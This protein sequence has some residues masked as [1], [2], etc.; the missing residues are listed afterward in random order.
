MM[1]TGASNPTILSM[2]CGLLVVL[3]ALPGTASGEILLED[4]DTPGDGLIKRDTE[5]GLGWLDLS[6]TGVP[7]GEPGISVDAILADAGG[8]M[9]RG[10]RYATESEVC[11][12]FDHLGLVP[13]P[14]PGPGASGWTLPIRDLIGTSLC[15][16]GQTAYSMGAYDDGGDPLLYG[17]AGYFG[18]VLGSN[19]VVVEPSIVPVGA[20]EAL[21]E[22]THFL[23]RASPGTDLPVLG[24]ATRSFLFALL[25]LAGGAAWR[26]RRRC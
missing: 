8:W 11:V 9:S 3:M 6:A 25:A 1:R 18:S 10:F 14:C 13:A 23:V 15:C 17:R 12:Y 20:S 4:L 26:R 19:G 21:T 22:Y 24:V 7:L 5:T 2:A 16:I